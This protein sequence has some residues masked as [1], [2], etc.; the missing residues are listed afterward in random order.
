MLRERRWGYWDLASARV[1]WRLSCL[2]RLLRPL[3]LLCLIMPTML[4]TPVSAY[5]EKYRFYT[6]QLGTKKLFFN[7]SDFLLFFDF[8]LSL[9][10]DDLL[11]YKLPEGYCPGTVVLNK[12]VRKHQAV[13]I[14]LVTKLLH[15][16]YRVARYYATRR[17]IFSLLMALDMDLS[18][19][20]TWN[21]VPP[22]LTPKVSILITS[23]PIYSSKLHGDSGLDEP[24]NTVPPACIQAV[25]ITF[26][27]GKMS[28]TTLLDESKPCTDTKSMR[29]WCLL[30]SKLSIQEHAVERR[31]L[32][33][34]VAIAMF[35]TCKQRCILTIKW[36][37][38]TLQRY[39]WLR[40]RPLN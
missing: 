23:T 39:T 19:L 37:D 40:G 24:R 12:N 7:E 17:S 25:L 33:S 36:D 22:M 16:S 11:T 14:E 38:T 30:L 32:H 35:L 3:Y 1:T 21:P 29:D 31:Q 28:L 27:V 8:I 34:L 2:L 10:L 5:V 26:F 18:P 13:V 4:V 6:R 9:V 15:C 20:N